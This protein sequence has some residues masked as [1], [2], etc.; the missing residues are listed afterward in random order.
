MAMTAQRDTSRVALFPGQGAISPGAGSAWTSAKS[1][2]LVQAISEVVNVDVEHLLLRADNDEVVRT[3]NAQLA[4][5]T[6]SLLVWK[7]LNFSSGAPAYFSGH[8]LGEFSALVAA[9]VIDYVSGARLVHARGVA[10]QQANELNPGTMAALMGGDENALERLSEI[11]SLWVANYN[12]EGQTVVAGSLAAIAELEERG[13]ELGWRRVTR[14]NVGGAFHSPLMASAAEPLNHELAGI[15]FQDTDAFVVANADG[16]L[17]QGGEVWRRLLLEQLTSPVQF[18]KGTLSLPQTVVHGI[19]MPP[20]SVLSGLVK[21]I[22]PFES[23]VN[24]E[25]GEGQ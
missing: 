22:R 1:W 19:E 18:L 14:L 24:V 2:S 20:G 8:S 23:L 7:Q 15:S 3:D 10:M 4:T 21:R 25:P 6:L 9:D 17:H 12:G 5:F 11:S 16:T 13:K